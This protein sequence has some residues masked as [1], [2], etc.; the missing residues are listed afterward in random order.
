MPASTEGGGSLRQT[1]RRPEQVT[2][3]IEGYIKLLHGSVALESL[4][5]SEER[6]HRFHRSGSE[7]R[8]D[9]VAV[10]VRVLDYQVTAARDE[11]AVDLQLPQD[12]RFRVVGIE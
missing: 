4:V 7:F 2:S 9:R 11:L 5:S 8:E 10:D 6:S 12:V 3:R 1:L